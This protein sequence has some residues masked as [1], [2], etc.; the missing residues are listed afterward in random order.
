MVLNPYLVSDD[1]INSVWKAMGWEVP[2]GFVLAFHL[3]AEW[4]PYE[5][6]KFLTDD[7]HIFLSPD[8][9]T[10]VGFGEDGSP[11]D[12]HIQSPSLVVFARGHGPTTADV[13]STGRELAESL[14]GL[15]DVL[16]G[17][18]YPILSKVYEAVFR[19]DKVETI[20]YYPAR[21]RVAMK[22]LTKE[23]LTNVLEP[24]N[25]G[26]LASLPDYIRLALRWYEKG[27][28]QESPVDKFIALYECSLVIVSRWHYPLYPE[29]YD[30]KEAPPRKMF[31]DWIRAI[32]K[33]SDSL[34]EKNKFRPFDVMVNRRNRILKASDL[35]IPSEEME[36]TISCTTQLLNWALM[37]N[38]TPIH[39]NGTE[40]AG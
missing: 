4:S 1:Q 11:S 37:E 36:D 5:E 35:N 2:T 9:W 8:D 12:F 26:I 3:P 18:G 34:D 6:V 23:D 25:T 31:G 38:V 17:G 22:G 33:P 20:K 39:R 14:A 15:C 21:T 7:Y 24:L 19:K 30:G 28:S 10:V 13:I 29:A 16:L 32:L 40:E 27:I